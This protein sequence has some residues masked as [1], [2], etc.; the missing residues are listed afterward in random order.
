MSEQDPIRFACPHCRMRVRAK[1]KAAGSKIRCPN[2]DCGEWMLVPDASNEVRPTAK[3][4]R[5]RSGPPR[6]RQPEEKGGVGKILQGLLGLL[7]LVGGGVYLYY[8]HPEIL[9]AIF[10]RPDYPEIREALKDKHGLDV[11]TISLLSG[12][13]GEVQLGMVT[14]EQGQTYRIAYHVERGQWTLLLGKQQP[15]AEQD[16]R[17][18]VTEYGLEASL[19][20]LKP[21][22]KGVGY[23]GEATAGTGEVFDVIDQLTPGPPLVGMQWLNLR[24]SSYRRWAQNG[25][26]RELKEEV[27]SVSE[28]KPNNKGL[29]LVPMHIGGLQG[30]KGP[31]NWQYISFQYATATTKSGRILQL[32]L[33]VQSTNLPE[34]ITRTNISLSWKDQGK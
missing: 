17:K 14:T 3:P 29:G 1:P 34:N 20:T 10:S 21:N 13:E 6:R 16:I 25:L 4:P 2:P 30:P 12:G 5:P 9:E 18:F 7:I 24:P 28:F 11:K 26:A 27:D 15:E 31:G 19:V 32:E 33:K 23:V 8:Y 22:A